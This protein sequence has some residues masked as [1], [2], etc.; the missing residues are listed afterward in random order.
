RIFFDMISKHQNKK[1]QQMKKIKFI[2]FSIFFYQISLLA[3]DLPENIKENLGINRFKD[4]NLNEILNQPL[5]ENFAFVQME[6]IFLI[7]I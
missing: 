4:E 5:K 6:N 7:I 1:K 2:I 3:N